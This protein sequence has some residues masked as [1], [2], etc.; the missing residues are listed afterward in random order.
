MKKRSIFLFLLI[1]IIVVLSCASLRNISVALADNTVKLTQADEEKILEY[2]D[3][4]TDDIASAQMGKMYSAFKLLGS[5][6][7]KLYIWVSKVEYLNIT[8]KLTHEG[9]DAVSL[10]VVL[11]IKKTDNGFNIISH[12]YPKDGKDYGKSLNKLFPSNIKYPT[13]EERLTLD[14]TTKA[15]AE[16]DSG[17]D[18]L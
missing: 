6:K 7:D 12:K 11:E 10:P 4:K 18:G 1:V 13:N 3:H 2:L 16:D 15:R 17:G 9:G 5:N 14:N 8:G